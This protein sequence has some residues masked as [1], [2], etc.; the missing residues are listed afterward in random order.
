MIRSLSSTTVILIF[1]F[2]CRS[3]DAT[4]V[5]IRCAVWYGNEMKTYGIGG[6]PVCFNNVDMG[7]GSQEMLFFKTRVLFP[8]FY[9]DWEEGQMDP[10]PETN[11]LVQLI[12][13][14]EVK[15]YHFYG[16]K[17]SRETIAGKPP[18]PIEKD[19]RILFPSDV[20]ALR[21]VLKRAWDRK[22][23]KRFD[24]KLIQMVYEPDEFVDDPKA[25]RIVKM[26]DGVCLEVHHYNIY[27]PITGS[28]SGRTEP[29]DVVRGAK[30]TLRQRNTQGKRLEYVF[31][32]G[33]FKGKDCKDS[34]GNAFREWL[35]QYWDAGL[36]KRHPHMI[37][38][39]NAFKHACGS[40]IPG[41]PETNDDSILGYCRWLVEQVK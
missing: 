31:Y 13:R 25:Q 22:I 35:I 4:K 8:E 33:P 28:P 9:I 18:G 37:Y 27:W 29:K 20:H 38:D 23:L 3:V 19:Q 41:G 11:P 16:V 39:L 21:Q 7:Y 5:A 32:Y 1:L 36:P 14:E 12:R 34:D 17:I 15:G 40:T 2:A 10:N 30:W 6:Y 26:M 24:Y